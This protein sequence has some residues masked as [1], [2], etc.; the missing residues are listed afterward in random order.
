MIHGSSILTSAPS[1]PCDRA[2]R[3]VAKLRYILS[4]SFLLRTRFLP[5]FQSENTPPSPSREPVYPPSDNSRSTS[6]P[7]TLAQPP[8]PMH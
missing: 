7:P 6:P 1:R 3:P 2:F 5:E 4:P 8:S